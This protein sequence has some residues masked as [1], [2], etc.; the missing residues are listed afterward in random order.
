MG[1]KVKHRKEETEDDLAEW[2]DANIIRI[3][4]E[5][6]SDSIRMTFDIYYDID[7]KD[8]VFTFPLIKDLKMGPLIIME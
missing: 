7:G 2:Y 5:Q 1:K 6:I 3:H 4:E 8:Q